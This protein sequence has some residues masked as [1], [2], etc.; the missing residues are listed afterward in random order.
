MLRTINNNGTNMV[1]ILNARYTKTEVDTLIATSYNKTETR[2]L[3][4][5][6]CKVSALHVYALYI[7]IY[8]PLSFSLSLSLSYSRAESHPH[9][10]AC[11]AAP[12][13]SR[14]F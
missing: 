8:I 12:G 3:A 11:K 6:S 2:N 13:S 7:Y 1:D 4:S 14:R 10:V 5:L 9:G